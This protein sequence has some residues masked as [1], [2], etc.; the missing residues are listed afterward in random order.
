V[1][2]GLVE[3]GLDHA[4]LVGRLHLDPQLVV[5]V[6]HVLLWLCCKPPFGSSHQSKGKNG[7]LGRFDLSR[8]ELGDR[9]LHSG[10][11]L[12]FLYQ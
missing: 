3:V 9:D 10:H 11:V 4:L 8:L 6:L 2:E 5:P 12:G 7:Y 1:L